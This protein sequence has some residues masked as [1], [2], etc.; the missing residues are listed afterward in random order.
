MQK[1]R[2]LYSWA[3][4]ICTPLFK[5]LYRYRYTNKDNIPQSGA[6]IICSNHI[7][8]SDPLLLGIGQKREIRY[9]AKSELFRNRF[10]ARL[11][12]G[13]GAFPVQRGAHD[14][15]VFDTAD[16]I[17]ENGEVLGIFPEGTRSKTGELLRMRSGAALIAAQMQVPVVPA[18]IT[19]KGGKLKFFN[20]TKISY[21][22]PITPQELGLQ[23]ETQTAPQLRAATRKIAQAIARLREND[24]F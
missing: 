4:V 7:S 1:K 13:L 5:L 19:P 20:P 17:L 16:S 8:Y 11:I 12:T 14:N 18:C 9:M 22:P 23:R 21:A 15:A 3:R 24:K 2:F 6:Y 10:F